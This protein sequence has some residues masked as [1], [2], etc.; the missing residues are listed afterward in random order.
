MA[1]VP[2]SSQGRARTEGDVGRLAGKRPMMGAS[3]DDLRHE[4]RGG[5]VALG[6]GAVGPIGATRTTRLSRPSAQ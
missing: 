4:S 5:P 6:V 3:A 1:K 2:W